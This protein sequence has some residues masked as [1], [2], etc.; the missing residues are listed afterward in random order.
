VDSIAIR[1]LGGGLTEVTAIVANQRLAPT[2][3]EQDIRNHITRPDWVTLDGGEVVAGFVVEDPLSGRAKEQVHN[4]RRIEVDNVPG[5]GTAT[6]R[7]VVRGK[8]PFTVTVDS[9]KGGVGR[10]RSD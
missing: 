6:V 8:G 9:E 10:R 5:M 1:S 7:W 3:T 4:P 2:H